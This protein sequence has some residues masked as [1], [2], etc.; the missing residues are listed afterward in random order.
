[1]AVLADVA[2]LPL[3][4]VVFFA[5]GTAETLF[6]NAAV[7][8][9]PAVVPKEQLARANGRLLGAQMVANELVAPPLGGLLFAT[10]AAV[11]FLLDAGSFAAAAALVAA[12]GGRFRV[13][14]PEGR[15]ATTL[16]GEIAEGVHWL[17]RNRLLR[18]LAV[19]IALMNLTLSATLSISVLYA[20]E[21]LGL[22]SVGYGLLLSSMAVGGISASLVAERVIGW[23]GP[24]TTMRLGLVIESSTHLVLALARSPVLVGASFALFGFHAMTWS[25]I[26]VSLRQELIPAR[27]LG[28][29]NSAYALFGFGSLSLGAVAGGLLA[30]R[31]GLTAPFWCSFAAMSVLTVACW[32]IL[33]ARAMAQARA[34]AAADADPPS[35]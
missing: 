9:L 24:A 21:R 34:Q 12:M 31:Y 5:L 2:T 3:L 1:V 6:D 32:P 26:S 15:A 35:A 4:Y 14:R 30:A 29:V 17:A 23:L 13:E 22:G 16:R 27:L 11:P 8:I 20:Q 28:R 33:S 7:S 10:A 18:I 25:V 19:A